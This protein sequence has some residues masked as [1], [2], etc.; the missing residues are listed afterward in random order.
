MQD[1]W[2]YSIVLFGM[3]RHGFYLN[4]VLWNLEVG[5]PGV[6]GP[7][8]SRLLEDGTARLLEDGTFRLLE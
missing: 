7:A 5:A 2:L 1:W 6:G 4:H 3:I 8:E